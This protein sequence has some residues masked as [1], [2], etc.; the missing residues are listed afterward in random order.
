M[1]QIMLWE[2]YLSKRKQ[3]IVSSLL[4]LAASLFIV[5]VMFH[6]TLADVRSRLNEMI[7]PQLQEQYAEFKAKEEI[8]KILRNRNL[9][10]DSAME[11]AQA[12]INQSK[13]TNIPVTLFLALMQKESNFSVDAV[14]SVNAMGIMQIHPVTWD[15]Y[16]KKLN[17]QV[18]RDKAFDPSTNIL[19]SAAILSDLRERYQKQGYEDADLWD[20]VLSAYYAGP[21]SVKDGLTVNHRQY[22]QRVRKYV[23][24]M[25][26]IIES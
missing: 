11:I 17:L 14:S 12:V 5:G 25:S 20:Y 19:V 21:E 16:V 9:E 24:E 7:N 3:W 2:Q 26:K 15:A 13:K 23:R 4:I 10:L 6:Q 18:S 8:Y 22:V 1:P